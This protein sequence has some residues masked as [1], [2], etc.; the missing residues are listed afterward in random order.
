M[1]NA[2]ESVHCLVDPGMPFCT[3]LWFLSHC[4][5]NKTKIMDHVITESGTNLV[6]LYII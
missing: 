6:T 1:I 4:I 5:N 2:N 3:Y